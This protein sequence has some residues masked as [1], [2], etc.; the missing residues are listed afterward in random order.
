MRWISLLV[1]LFLVAPA[2]AH[3]EDDDTFFAP[4]TGTQIKIEVRDG[5][6]YITCNG[7]PNHE[8]GQFPSR[9]NPGTITAQK[10]EFK[11]PAEPVVND[12]LTTIGSPG[13]RMGRGGFVGSPPL[14][15]GVAINGVVFDPTTAEWFNDDPQTGWHIEAI[16][17]RPMLGID[18]SNAHVQPPTGTYHYHGVPL[19]LVKKMTGDDFGKK[20]VQVA[21]AAD[22]FPVYAMW[23]YT[24]PDDAKSK[25]QMLRSSYQLKS[26]SRPTGA[27]SP[28][29]KFDGTYT[30]DYEFKKGSG[31]LDEC[32]GRFGVTPEFPNGTYYYVLT[33]KFPFVPRWFKATPDESFNHHPPGGGRRGPNDRG[34]DDRGP[35]GRGPNGPPER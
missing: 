8:T 33:N 19:G 11:M 32:N 26:G 12:K 24:K 6:R 17:P 15:F 3:L 35:G 29:G 16:G 5:I 10:Y 20:M 9:T 28:G 4:T 2:N 30:Q 1:A 34:P 31:D 25:V 22:G 23:G 13:S 27:N 7:L 14:L 18:N 21:W